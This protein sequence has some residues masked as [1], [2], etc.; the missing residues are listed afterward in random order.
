MRFS[1]E[2]KNDSL[3][4]FG[5]GLIL[6]F[7]LLPLLL[8]F[9]FRVNIYVTWEGA[10]R[11]FLG[12]IPYK[13]FG[14]P[15]GYG[16]W[17][18]PFIFFKIF[19]PYMITLVKAQA[20]INLISLFTFRGILKLFKLDEATVFFSILV[21]C[22]SFTL[23]NFWPW[24][25]HTVFFFELIALYFVLLYVK[26]KPKFYYLI[27]CFFFVWLALLTKQDGG[28]LTVLFVFSILIIDFVYSRNWKSLLIA[29]SSFIFFYL[30][31]V[32]PFLQYDFGY[33]FNYGQS[34][35]YSRVSSYHF[36]NDI[37]ARSEW[38]KGHLLAVVI[39]ISLRINKEGFKASLRDKNFVLF[40]LF[41]IGIILQATI[42][43]VTSFSPP[44]VNL[45]F[46]SFAIAF[47]LY[48]LQNAV[49]FKNSIVFLVVLIFI[50]FWKSD[51]YWKYSQPIISKVAPSL[52]TPPPSD[53]VAKGNWAAKADTVVK[54]EPVIWI[55]SDFKSLNRIKIPKNTM[56]GLIHI[57][58]LPVVK[59]ENLKVLNMSNLTFLAYE[60]N[61]EPPHGQKFPL[62]FHKGVAVFDREIEMLCN[63]IKNSE[64]DIILFED[65]P[66]V[67]NFFPYEVRDC[68]LDNYEMS[69]KFLSPTGYKTD[70]VEVYIRK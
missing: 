51:N 27:I 32:L 39:I 34:P 58:N 10:Y 17:I 3:K 22:L 30:T 23:I 61:Y 20:F 55:E 70:S 31:L 8:K 38:L 12:Q 36:I 24:Y 15:L 2:L 18:I 14:M 13:D 19:G 54:N 45:Y 52:L 50:F 43:Q 63:A 67:N 41:T 7:S 25:N 5:F 44:T 9:P 16:F 64:F 37:F 46:H 53:V 35:H 59:K 47:I 26:S 69:A 62:W 11:M 29:I 33:W 49:K 48:A 28:A 6:L 42:I 60:L 21:M 40:A 4:W 65:M 68:A 57:K 66:D 56:E 1:Y